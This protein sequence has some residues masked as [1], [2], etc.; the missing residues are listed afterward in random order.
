MDMVIACFYGFL[1]V[2][3]IKTLAFIIAGVLIGVVVGIL[4]AIGA[5]SGMA[6]ILP[7]FYSMDPFAALP[8]L[9]SLH[10]V[11]TIG[12]SVTTVLLNIPGDSPNAATLID[13]FP[14]TRK[15]EAG[16]ALGAVLTASG[17]GGFMG[18]VMGILC[19]PLV[20]PL[21][22]AMKMPEM[23]FLVLVGLAFMATLGEGGQIKA[24]ISGG[25]GLLTAFIGFQAA[26][27]TA[28]FTFD[29]AFLFDGLKIAPV[30]MGLFAGSELIEMAVTGE[31]ISLVKVAK[32]PWRQMLEGC[33][34]VF[35]YYGVWFRSTVIG[36][37][38]GILPG[39]GSTGAC[40]VAYGQ[41]KK[42]SKHPELFGTGHVEGVIAPEAAISACHGGDLLTTIAFG[43]PGS[44]SMGLLLAAY[45]L[46]GIKP[47]P[48]LLID[49]TELS[50]ALLWATAISKLIAALFCFVLAAYLV[51]LT[52]VP[53]DY[54]MTSIVPLIFVSAYAVNESLENILVFLVFSGL[55]LLMKKVG[56]SRPSLLLG[57]ILGGMFE[58]YLWL[59][60]KLHGPLFFLRP[61]SLAMI[62]LI[63]FLFAAEP[64]KSALSK[65]RKRKSQYL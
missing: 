12:G 37:I 52:T 6:L 18:I 50:F 9:I 1:A 64:V 15:G 35:R 33:K 20:V 55:G 47:G 53:P 62:A 4:P 31:C 34:D 49:H 28:R 27:G 39:I 8:F 24:I 51:R 65:S 48:G 54:L 60:I 61:I 56:F 17:T 25:L 16:R 40:F 43:I 26:T 2:F 19:I 46:V 23:F 7:F 11:S 58:D 5:M 21:V 29:S 44:G 57:F 59:S 22:L 41:A 10:S 13:G 3:K 42:T 32:T 14:M 30:A 45:L 36:Y 63:V 38:I